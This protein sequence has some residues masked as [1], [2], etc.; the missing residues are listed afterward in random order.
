LMAACA[1][2]VSQRPIEKVPEPEIASA[3]P[4][5]PTRA[6]QAEYRM[7]ERPQ[8]RF[9]VSLELSQIADRE[10]K[11]R[12]VYTM[13]LEYPGPASP[14]APNLRAYFHHDAS[15]RVVRF[16][17][18]PETAQAS[19][20]WQGHL[21]PFGFGLLNQTANGTI[22]VE[23]GSYSGKVHFNTSKSADGTLVELDRRSSLW[24]SVFD[25][26]LFEDGGAVPLALHAAG[27]WYRRT[28][29]EWG[30]ELESIQTWPTL[31]PPHQAPMQGNLMF[32]GE[33]ED[34][35]GWGFSFRQALEELLQREAG[36]QSLLDGGCVTR[37][38]HVAWGRSG[39]DLHP[40]L[41]IRSHQFDIA[42]EAKSAAKNWTLYYDRGYGGL[43]TWQTYGPSD[44]PK[45]FVCEFLGP[46]AA[47]APYVIE[48]GK[49]VLNGE[50]THLSLQTQSNGIGLL[51][52]MTDEELTIGIDRVTGTLATAALAPTDLSRLDRGEV[53]LP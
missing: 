49:R 50:P 36:A 8:D 51:T 4:L 26:W 29:L 10:L 13:I 34:L 46:K 9:S 21:S 16:D 35:F 53:S 6:F 3:Q 1:A 40:L 37:F 25:A 15:W 12:P 11:L 23:L 18:V 7:S 2:P 30:V 48:A 28:N 45:S 5:Y 42:L 33:Q 20:D 22:Q 39:Y 52:A 24:W 31:W 47:S 38:A 14:G 41:Q 32:P 19:W 44:L 27:D 17:W 43:E